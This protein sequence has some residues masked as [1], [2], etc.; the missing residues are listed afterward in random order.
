ME[1]DT[2]SE[3]RLVASTPRPFVMGINYWPRKKA[4]YWW[5]QFDAG[6]VRAE[7]AEIAA[8]GARVV[9]IFLLWEDFQP[10][11][12]RLD[13]RRLD[14]LTVVMDAAHGAGLRVMPTFFVGNMSGIF[15]LPQ[16]AV[17]DRPNLS[18]S[19]LMVGGA[20]SPFI[21]RDIFE[22]PFML[23]AQLFQ[24]RGVVSALA[25]HPAL[26]GWDLSN[27]LDEVRNPDGYDGGWLWSHLLCEEV[28]KLDPIHPVT[29]GAHVP[30]L[31][32]YNG[33]S[34]VDLAESNDYLSM[35]GYPLY[36][37]V[38]R[39]PLDSEFVP[40]LNQLTA[41]LGGKA[42]LFQEFGLCTAAPG[43]PGHYI[44]DEFLG[45]KK[46]QYLAGEEEGGVYYREVMEKLYRVGSLGQFA[47]CFADYDPSL[48][49]R[50]PFD[51]AVRERTFGI[52][53]ADGS[54]KPAA[55]QFRAFATWLKDAGLKGW[56]A[57]KVPFPTTTEEYYGDPET[58]FP[59][60]YQWYL[61]RRGS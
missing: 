24:L 1:Y 20:Y 53:R 6:E 40:F 26:A 17:T 31:S 43:E 56:G 52:T 38:A 55:E 32:R 28:R 29:Y 7:F 15:W 5:K 19:L 50:P 49:D 3:T 12:W 13:N 48:W 30:S 34:V 18:P 14:N 51:R 37:D 61:S 35:H 59:R 45:Q 60:M 27:E 25:T 41:Y 21:P 16:W 46:Q 57:E 54:W 11:P 42:T 33:I 8:I 39:G 2:P 36:S 47:W 23:R 44:E 58:H 4:M 22:E 9:R 10:E